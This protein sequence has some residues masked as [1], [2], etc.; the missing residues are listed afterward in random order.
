M[1]TLP[2]DLKKK[3]WYQEF[4]FEDAEKQK[5]YRSFLAE[6][7]RGPLIVALWCITS[8]VILAI[9]RDVIAPTAGQNLA[10]K[11]FLR[12]II[13]AFCLFSLAALK[14]GYIKTPNQQERL[15]NSVILTIS[16]FAWLTPFAAG[17][18]QEPTLLGLYVGTTAVLMMGISSTIRGTT[19][20]I[21][22]TLIA[23]FLSTIPKAYSI[24]NIDKPIVLANSVILIIGFVVAIHLQIAIRA[25]EL[26]LFQAIWISNTNLENSRSANKSKRM[27]FTAI[28]HDYRQPLSALQTY[29]DLAVQLMDRSQMQQLPE[30]IAK[31]Q[32]SA[33]DINA[34]LSNLLQLSALDAAT[35]NATIERVDL[36]TLITALID[37]YRP[38]ANQLGIRIIAKI[39]G[40][41]RTVKTNSILLHQ[42]L[43]NFLGNSIKHH[44]VELEDKRIHLTVTFQANRVMICVVDNG[45]GLGLSKNK[46]ATTA[47]QKE[48]FGSEIILNAIVKLDHHTHKQRNRI[49][50]HTAHKITIYAEKST[51]VKT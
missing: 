28:A 14:T 8:M 18:Q 22:F 6:G 2:T 32:R 25:R 1:N 37:L 36:T 46:G 39:R 7:S 33:T 34:N 42:I 27:F 3:R 4:E 19:P 43:G 11:H 9:L 24:W 41:P 13:F 38:A 40:N 48:Q 21:L 16:F 12:A 29:I 35:E 50:G 20:V 49:N 31:I 15:T 45:K 47:I 51:H 10:V 23:L 5:S 44:R 26:R 17:N 30:L